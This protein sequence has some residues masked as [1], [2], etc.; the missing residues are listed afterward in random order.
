M[1]ED[2]NKVMVVI[3]RSE[4]FCTPAM[5]SGER[6]QAAGIQGRASR[7]VRSPGLAMLAGPRPDMLPGT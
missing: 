4:L 6:A 2:A 1:R 3:G 7:I 5:E